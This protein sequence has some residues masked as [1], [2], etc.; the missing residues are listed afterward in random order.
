MIV[1][2]ADRTISLPDE[3]NLPEKDVPVFLAALASQATHFITGDF[4]HFGLYRGQTLG[5]V[6]IMAPADYLNA[7]D[8]SAAKKKK[9]S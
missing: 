9:K 2:E 5:G 6:T 1:S 7:T 8:V 4:R 3:M